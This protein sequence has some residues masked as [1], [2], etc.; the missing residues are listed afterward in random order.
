LE[1]VLMQKYAYGLFFAFLL[2]ACGSND[3]D[4][5]LDEGTVLDLSSP[6][7]ADLS[8][9]PTEDAGLDCG[10]IDL[11]APCNNNETCQALGDT[12]SCIDHYWI[13]TI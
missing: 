5:P 2:A 4:G 1:D 10:D 3:L 11:T 6:A 8:S 12:C 13:C 9:L 7:P